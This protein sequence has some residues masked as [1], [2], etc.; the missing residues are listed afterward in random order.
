M[1]RE[2]CEIGMIMIDLLAVDA[3]WRRVGKPDRNENF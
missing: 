2:Q 3:D 1:V